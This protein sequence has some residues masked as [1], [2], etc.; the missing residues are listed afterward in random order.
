MVEKKSST[1]NIPEDGRN[2]SGKS[3]WEEQKLVMG[4]DTLNKECHKI[5]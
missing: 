4:R 2:Q 3:A 5:V 1:A